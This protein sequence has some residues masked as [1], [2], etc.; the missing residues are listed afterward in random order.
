MYK[1]RDLG[2]AWGELKKAKPSGEFLIVDILIMG[3]RDYCL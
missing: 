3:G 2:I 1:K